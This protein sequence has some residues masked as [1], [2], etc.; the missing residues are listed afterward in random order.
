MQKENESIKF[1][2]YRKYLNGKNYFKI[3]SANHFEEI[4]RLGS[5]YLRQ[6]HEVKILPDRN[7]LQDLL[8]NYHSFALVI[9]QEE[10]EAVQQQITRK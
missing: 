4:Q 1:P 3:L 6:S 7:F 9:S 10:Y 2:Q 5:Q 8:V